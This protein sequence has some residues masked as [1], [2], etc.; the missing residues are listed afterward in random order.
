MVAR[1]NVKEEGAVP[2]SQIQ[3]IFWT[4]RQRFIFAYYVFYAIIDV[5]LLGLISWN[6]HKH[7][8]TWTNYPNGMYYHALGLGLFATIFTLLVSIFH[9]ALGHLLLTFT[10]FACGVLFGTVAGILTATPFGH[11][12]QCGN[13]VDRF[14]PQ[15]RPFVDDC[16]KVTATNGLSWAMFALATAGFFFMLQDKYACTSKRDHVYINYEAPE[17][18]KIHDEEEA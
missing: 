12:L 9:W 3:A 1:N 8:N 7:G 10:F 13:P 18:K 4:Q 15:Y 2:T 6:I 17:P 14:P 5:T 11:G 16:A